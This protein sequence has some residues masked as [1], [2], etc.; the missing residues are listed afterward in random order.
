MIASTETAP[1][2]SQWRRVAQ[3]ASWTIKTAL[4]AALM[5]FALVAIWYW[6]AAVTGYS[7]GASIRSAFAVIATAGN[8]DDW[9]QLAPQLNHIV[10]LIAFLTFAWRVLLT[11]VAANIGARIGDW[12]HIEVANRVA[13]IVNKLPGRAWQKKVL[14]LLAFVLAFG[15]LVVTTARPRPQEPFPAANDTTPT[16]TAA[17][18]LPSGLV[19]SGKVDVQR[20]GSKWLLT[21][22]DGE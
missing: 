19:R 18:V 13:P 3:T 9:N 8:A 2:R 7:D 6:A 20:D 10:W 5:P 17:V 12:V 4:F 22:S 14:L 16:A 11:P 21:F 1:Y 15:L